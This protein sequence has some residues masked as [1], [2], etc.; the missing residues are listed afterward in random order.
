MPNH[1]A[2]FKSVFS[3]AVGAGDM[4]GGGDIQEHARMR[5]PQRDFIGGAMQG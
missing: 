5:C 1:F 4:A 2:I 3:A